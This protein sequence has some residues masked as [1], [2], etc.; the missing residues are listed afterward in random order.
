MCQPCGCSQSG[1]RQMDDRREEV[2]IIDCSA[3]QSPDEQW[4]S[5]HEAYSLVCA[6]NGP[7][8]AASSIIKRAHAGLIRARAEYYSFEAPTDQRGTAE[9]RFSNALLTK[10]FWWADGGEGLRQNWQSGDFSTLNRGKYE[11]KAI[12][13]SFALLRSEEH[14]SDLQSLMRNSYA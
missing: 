6:R 12:G 9:H 7:D 1:Q 14:K 10:D 3:E 11:W 2:M 4:L 5:A 13:V 8:H